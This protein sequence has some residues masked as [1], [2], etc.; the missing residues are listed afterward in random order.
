MLRVRVEAVFFWPLSA[1]PLA[2]TNT[3]RLGE[4]FFR[5]LALGGNNWSLQPLGNGD[6]GF[7]E[8]YPTPARIPS[9]RH[10]QADCAH[11]AP[12]FWLNCLAACWSGFF[13]LQFW[14]FFGVGSIPFLLPGNIREMRTFR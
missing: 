4:L 3:E 2:W 1:L 6:S 12:L 11:G 9:F 8:K 13:V 14:S 7:L 10:K 5:V